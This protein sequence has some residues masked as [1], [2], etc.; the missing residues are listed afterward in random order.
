MTQSYRAGADPVDGRYKPVFDTGMRP[1][2]F[3][4]PVLPRSQ[5]LQIICCRLIY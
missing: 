4:E 5:I 3:A 1:I 2:D